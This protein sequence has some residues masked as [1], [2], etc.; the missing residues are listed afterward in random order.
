M[1]QKCKSATQTRSADSSSET[2]GAGSNDQTSELPSTSVKE[3]PKKKLCSSLF[4][5]SRP[6]LDAS[7][8]SGCT[9]TADMQL[10]KYISDINQD[11][12]DPDQKSNLFSA[13]EYILLRPLFSTLFSIPATSAPVERVFSQGGIIMRPHR[14]KIGDDLLE[15]LMYLRCNGN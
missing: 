3:P 12:F 15:M 5:Y 4:G 14:A 6:K 13:K 2:S 1:I 7:Q 8:A 10:T 9:V 11:D